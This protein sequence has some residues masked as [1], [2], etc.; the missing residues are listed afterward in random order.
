MRNCQAEPSQNSYSSLFN[1][2][3][4]CSKKNGTPEEATWLSKCVR[5]EKMGCLPQKDNGWGVCIYP[6]CVLTCR[7]SSFFLP[8]GSYL[9]ELHFP[10]RQSLAASFIRPDYFIARTL[11]SQG[12]RLAFAFR[13]LVMCWQ[14]AEMLHI[15]GELKASSCDEF[16]QWVSLHSRVAGASLPYKA[17]GTLSIIASGLQ[18]K[19]I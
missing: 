14:L 3:K 15:H 2:I 19:S 5:P 4:P 1:M 7:N 9:N 8:S 12:K 10:S 13:V 16:R 11:N 6:S 18:L 17:S